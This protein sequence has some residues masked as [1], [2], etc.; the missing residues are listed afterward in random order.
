[1]KIQLQKI[2]KQFMINACSYYKNQI[3]ENEKNYTY[4]FNSTWGDLENTFEEVKANEIVNSTK[5]QKQVM[6]QTHMTLLQTCS[7]YNKILTQKKLILD[8]KLYKTQT[9]FKILNIIIQDKC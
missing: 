1:M 8:F 5:K 6:M 3:K 2:S 4:N 9:F 7:T